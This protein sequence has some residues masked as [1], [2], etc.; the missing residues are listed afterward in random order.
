MLGNP[1]VNRLRSR[2][3]EKIAVFGDCNRVGRTSHKHAEVLYVNA[4]SSFG[5]VHR[6]RKRV[7]RAAHRQDRAVGLGIIRVERIGD[8]GMDLAAALCGNG[9]LGRD[10]SVIRLE[11]I[12]AIAAPVKLDAD[13]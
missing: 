1:V 5:L 4:I 6:K 7:L 3:L 13:R 2:G 12:V 9:L 10:P 11:R 8:G